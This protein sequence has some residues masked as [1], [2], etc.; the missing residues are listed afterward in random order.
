MANVIELVGS[1]ERAVPEECHVMSQNN[2]WP[3][4]IRS[5]LIK[6]TGMA[7]RKLTVHS[8]C[9]GSGLITNNMLHI[10]HESIWLISQLY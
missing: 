10:N 4:L 5:I 7:L 8:V 9:R 1:G 3:A 6:Q 2:G